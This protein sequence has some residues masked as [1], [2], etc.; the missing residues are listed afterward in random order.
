M[1]SRAPRRLGRSGQFMPI[2]LMLIFTVVTLLWAVFDVYLVSKAK[3]KAQ[4]I[5]DAVALAIASLEARSINVV[6]DRNQWMNNLYPA[7]TK[8]TDQTLPGISAAH[9]DKGQRELNQTQ[10]FST[11]GNLVGEV[12]QAQQMFYNAYNQFIGAGGG[13]ASEGSGAGSLID[14]LSQIDGIDSSV[15]VIVYNSANQEAAAL[16]MAQ[17]M[18]KQTAS[19][20]ASVP[21]IQLANMA[22]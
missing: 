12:N 11:Y 6:C 9:T 5:A 7:G 17:Q 19:Q 13:T 22:A 4:N 3:L 20:L 1:K 18:A 8:P 10:A 2:S 21:P 15:H 16:S 14:I